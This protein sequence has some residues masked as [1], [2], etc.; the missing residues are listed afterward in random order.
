MRVLSCKQG[1]ADWLEERSFRRCA[2]E[3]PAMMG[4][5]RHTTRSEL[6][7]LKAGGAP[8]DVS[9][10]KQTLFDRGH[11]SE[12]AARVIAEE[13][14]GDELYPCTVVSD[15]GTYLA[16]LDGMT[17]D[18]KTIWEHKLYSADLA[19]MVDSDTLSPEY[20]AQIDHQMMVTGAQKCVFMA[21]DGT[22]DYCCWMWVERN[23]AR[24]SALL[25]GWDQFALD[26][27]N[28]VHREADPVVVGVSPE[29][30]PAL[31]LQMAG[32]VVLSNLPEFRARAEVIF[33]A[34]NLAVADDQ[35]LAD[36]KSAVEYCAETE[37]R[38]GE[39]RAN[40]T[41]QPESL[42]RALAEMEAIKQEFPRRVRLI[43]E[44]EIKDYEAARR[45][46]I[47]DEGERALTE[48]SIKLA[49]QIGASFFPVAKA[50]F[51]GAIKGKRST[52][53]MR[54]A[55][56]TTLAHAKIAANELADRMAENLKVLR[57][58]DHLSLFPDAE[59]L[60]VQPADHVEA[61]MV[62]RIAKAKDEAEL[63][64]M[65]AAEQQRR[66]N[67]AIAN[68]DL[69]A[70]PSIGEINRRDEV[71]HRAGIKAAIADALATEGRLSAVTAK[72][73]VEAIAAGKIPYLQINQGG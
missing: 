56:A 48:H 69:A 35:S 19:G 44:S 23:E 15:D 17:D 4:V 31:R 10:H 28:Y 5:S 9:T 8:A 61:V 1:D 71:M 68:A 58:S 21:S 43:L 41:A 12:A 18:G 26:L 51:T 3:A 54:D 37:K 24:I 47:V 72:K 53:A 67:E 50:D 2:S 29:S 13:L 65:S 66:A 38:I 59:A 73:L 62:G 20:L 70:R 64:A 32:D 55:V 34:I 46:A 36:A 25:D 16:S 63:R 30:L 39:V 52:V 60:A 22:R 7:R 57:E 33:G 40:A 49:A 14:L 42:T 6:L 11:E 27:A 45:R